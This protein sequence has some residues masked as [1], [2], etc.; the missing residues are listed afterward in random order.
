M[1]DAPDEVD[2]QVI[3]KCDED[4]EMGSFVQVE[5]TD[6]NEYDLFGVCKG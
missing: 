5:I 1:A 6:A 3:F 4:L 2:G